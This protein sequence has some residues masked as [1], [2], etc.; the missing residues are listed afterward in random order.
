MTASNQNPDRAAEEILKISLRWN[1]IALWSC[2]MLSAAC[3]VGPKYTRP[4]VQTPPAYK[5]IQPQGPNSSGEWKTAQPQD[6]VVRGEWWEIFGDPALD[7]LEKKADISNQNIAAAVANVLAARAAIRQAH[8]QYFPT[9]TANLSITNSRLATGFGKALGITFTNYSLPFDA[10]WEPDLWGR[11]Q[12]MVKANSFAAQVSVAD[13]ENVRL[14]AQAELATDYFQL[15]S[16]DALKQVIDS[17]VIAYQEA[18]EL[19]RDRLTAGIESDEA[20]AQAEAQL[21]ATQAQDTNLEVLRAKFEHA[22]A[23]LMGEPASTFSV[24]VETIKASPPPIPIGIPS[25]LLE[26]RPDIAAAERAVAEANSQIGI[27][28]AAF[29]PTVTLSA[30]AGLQSLS[31]TK[32]LEW[33]SR[34]WSLGPGLAQTIFDAGLR[35]ATVQQFHAFYDQTVAHYRQTELAAFQQVEDNLAA[36]R[37]LT[38]VIEQQDSAIESAER[39]LQEADVRYKSGIDPYLNVITAQTALLNDRQAAVN[40]RMQQMI[41]SVQLIKALGG[42]WNSSQIPSAKELGT[43]ASTV[44]SPKRN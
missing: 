32:W 18:L 38:Q 9:L 13:L 31:I 4:S 37:I 43:A 33:P 7:N 34:V 30:S 39:S 5:E 28:R 40:F 42:G 21:K 22:I 35:K 44:S 3:A 10:S 14:S 36:L 8:A 20:V 6:G 27:A 15:R 23:L 19:N 26:R 16:Q 25:E 2:V 17:T 12:S 29:Y 11:V 41:A 1:V 24:P